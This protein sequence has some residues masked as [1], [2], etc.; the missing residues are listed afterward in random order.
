M[1]DFGPFAKET[2][3]STT[4]PYNL[5]GAATGAQA[6][7]T[8]YTLPVTGV[9]SMKNRDDA[10]EWQNFVGTVSSGSPNTLSVDSMIQS[11]NAD[12]ELTW[13]SGTKEVSMVLVLPNKG[14]VLVGIGDGK[15]RNLAVGSDNQ[16][17]VADSAQTEGVNWSSTLLAGDGSASTP[18][19]SFANDSN[20]GLYSAANGTLAVTRNGN[21]ELTLDFNGLGIKQTDVQADL[22]IGGGTELIWT[23]NDAGINAKNWR[24]NIDANGDWALT[25][26]EDDYSFGDNVWKIERTG[27]I[28][29]FQEWYVDSTVQ[30]RVDTSGIT[31]TTLYSTELKDIS[32]AN[33]NLG[34]GLSG[35]VTLNLNNGNIFIG[36]FSGA[37]TFAISNV[38][39]GSSATLTLYLTD[40]S[41]T[42][43]YTWP[44]GTLWPGGTEPSWTAN[45]TDIV[46]LST[47]DGGTTW[48]GLP[49]AFGMA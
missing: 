38:P 34:T 23:R 21:Q 3:T 4:S 47:N 13:S 36:S 19:I 1:A 7:D 44:T 22:H 9:F 26:R 37:T 8:L 2:S 35:T 6:F 48:Y 45:G 15:M 39:T 5:G 40:T 31:G 20:T 28:I 49:A 14:D 33:V 24:L 30:L 27:T 46:S 10:T 32:E 41:G 43:S 12:N 42:P 18:S 25:T 29:D 16:I 11:S 17:L